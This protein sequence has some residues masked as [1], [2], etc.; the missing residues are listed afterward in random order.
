M[1]SSGG[2]KGLVTKEGVK[3]SSKQERERIMSWNTVFTSGRK[4]I[5]EALV[6]W[7]NEPWSAQPGN[8]GAPSGRGLVEV[9]ADALELKV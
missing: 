6:S 2:K 3:G 1:T 7:R 5:I 8:K 9:A 4:E